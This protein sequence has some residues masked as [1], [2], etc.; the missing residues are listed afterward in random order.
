MTDSSLKKKHSGL[1]RD[2][3]IFALD[4]P[5]PQKALEAVSLVRAHVGL[6][7][8]GLELFSRSGPELVRSIQDEHQSGVFLDL[9]YYDIPATVY[10]SVRAASDLGVRFVTVHASGGSRMLET[11]VKAAGE[12]TQILAVTVLTSFSRRDLE[13]EGFDAS[14]KLSDLVL[15]RANS[16]KKAGCAGVICSGAEIRAIKEK[17]GEDFLAVVPGIRP[18]WGEVPGDDQQRVVTPEKAIRDGADYLVIGRPIR[19]APDPAEA[20]RRISGE[21]SAAFS[22]S[23]TF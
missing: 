17:F 22:R 3:L 4:Y 2:R 12:D 1:G 20:A 7:K 5:S 16:A 13:E 23:G 15:R 18:D 21:M 9:K 19:V 14:V 10:S 11:A 8:I 6:F